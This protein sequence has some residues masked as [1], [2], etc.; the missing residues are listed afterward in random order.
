MERVRFMILKYC[1]YCKKEMIH[2]SAYSCDYCRDSKTM[3]VSGSFRL[4]RKIRKMCKC[5]HDKF[6]HENGK[7][8]LRCL[9]PKYEFH[10]EIWS[11]YLQ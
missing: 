3:I 10:K 5:E 4:E 6:F 9:C 11:D 8:C 2:D 1:P 7:H